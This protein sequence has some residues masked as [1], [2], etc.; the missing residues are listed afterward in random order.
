M[1]KSCCKLTTFLLL[2]VFLFCSCTDTDTNSSSIGASSVPSGT[3]KPQPTETTVS[4]ASSATEDPPPTSGPPATSAETPSGT[5]PDGTSSGRNTEPTTVSSTSSSGGVITSGKTTAPTTKPSADPSPQPSPIVVKTPK[6]SGTTAYAGNGVVIDASNLSEGYV[7]VKCTS[8]A[9]R[10]KLMVV[11][12]SQTFNYDLNKEGRYEVFPLQA[13]DGEYRLRVMENISGTR[14]RELFS[15]TV[16]VRLTNAF[17]PFLYP[18]QYVSFTADSQAVKKSYELCAGVNSD[19]GKIERIYTYIT[20]HVVY[21]TEKAA[22]VKSGYLPDV[23]ETL[24]TE[25]GICF[26][27]AALMAAMLRAQ[28]IPTQL[29]IG[30]VAPGDVSHAWNLVYTKEKGWIAFKISFSGG[31]WKLMDA[32]FGASKGQDIEKYIGD[33]SR[34]T[35][36]RY[37]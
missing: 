13:G 25:K 16:S 1:P 10:L 7:M 37:Y 11:S 34:Y 29:A 14:Y 35:E 24:R 17:S 8:S 30:T 22:T 21:D 5:V 15:V 28:N 23:D 33:G 36:L 26:D 2:L 19:L 32:T 18:S 12:P 31:T 3:E 27:Y 4:S 20:G 9:P 6:A